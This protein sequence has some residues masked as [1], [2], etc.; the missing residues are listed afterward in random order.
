MSG[1]KRPER[2]ERRARER[3]WRKLAADRQRLA[4]MAPGGSPDRPIVVSAPSVIEVRARS[5]PC[6]LCG[7]S[8]RIDDQAA[9]V[10]EGRVLTELRVSCAACGIAR[11]LYFRT[12]SPL[13]S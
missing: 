4:A 10:S 6:P 5:L 9:T 3:D 8:L 13:P 1:R 11:S 12:G 7:G 2:T